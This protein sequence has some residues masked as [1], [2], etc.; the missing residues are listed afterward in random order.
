[1]WKPVPQKLPLRSAHPITL[2]LQSLIFVFK[3]Q[4]NRSLNLCPQI[5]EKSLFECSGLWIVL[6]LDTASE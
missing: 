6:F 4:G 2:N 1:M 5:K 3:F